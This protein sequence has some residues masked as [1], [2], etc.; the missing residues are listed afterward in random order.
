MSSHSMLKDLLNKDQSDS[1]SQDKRP[2]SRNPAG[3]KAGENRNA[4]PSQPHKD[5]EEFVPVNHEDVE[6]VDD[7][8][9]DDE[10]ESEMERVLRPFLG[11]Q[12]Q[13]GQGGRGGVASKYDDLHPYT[14][15]L[16]PSNVEQCLA[17]EEAAFPEHERCSR[18]KVHLTSIIYHFAHF[19]QSHSNL[20]F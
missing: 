5:D 7:D 1:N 14:Q 20:G 8:D 18:E 6:D 17:L 9:D 2:E 15:I 19:H 11:I 3:D 13:L 4:S 10:D 12:R 16:G